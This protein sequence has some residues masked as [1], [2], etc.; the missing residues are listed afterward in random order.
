MRTDKFFKEAELAENTEENVLSA[1]L[2]DTELAVNTEESKLTAF[3][4][5][6]ELKGALKAKEFYELNAAQGNI[7]ELQDTK[8]EEF[9]ELQVILQNEFW[10]LS[11]Q[12]SDNIYAALEKYREKCN[13]ELININHETEATDERYKLIK[14]MYLFFNVQGNS[15]EITNQITN[16]K[17]YLNTHECP[18]NIPYDLIA[19][20]QL[21]V[22]FPKPEKN[23]TEYQ[24]FYKTLQ[25][26]RSNCLLAHR[27]EIEGKHITN[28]F[29]YD[30]HGGN[31]ETMV[32]EISQSFEHF[33]NTRKDILKQPEFNIL[34]EYEFMNLLD[35]VNKDV[36]Q[37]VFDYNEE[38]IPSHVEENQILLLAPTINT[39]K[40][41]HAISVAFYNNL[42]LISDK[43][44]VNP[45]AHLFK[46]QGTADDLKKAKTKIALNLV[47]FPDVEAPKI[48]TELF[49]NKLITALN[50]KKIAYI[51]LQ[52]QYGENC[53]WS[54]SAKSVLLSALFFRMYN[55]V[56]NIDS[57]KALSND[58]HEKKAIDLAGFYSRK[59]RS[60]WSHYDQQH[61]LESYIEH[62]PE[63]SSTLLAYIMLKNP[64]NKE[65]SHIIN[66][67]KLVNELGIVKAID[68]ADQL[69]IKLLKN[70]LGEDS[71]NSISKS[72]PVL[73]KE[74]STKLRDLCIFTRKNNTERVFLL[75]DFENTEENLTNTLEQLTKELI[76]SEIS[77]RKHPVM[78]FDQSTDK[79]ILNEKNQ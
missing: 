77:S 71:Y 50:M 32:A 49:T 47:K 18:E 38:L 43:A 10:A 34:G 37:C 39:E 17:K 70:E 78:F 14:M 36:S 58:E 64:Q 59:I 57:L 45:G 72:F 54:S 73:L 22:K 60:L 66:E 33:L 29:E 68:M 24:K 27:S 52:T 25:T 44:G 63:L 7:E 6:A 40:G 62:C 74:I 55:A 30:L 69:V 35:E 4:L 79:D 65:Y 15:E 23:E 11:E 21:F 28:N 19:K 13:Q 48:T 26:I 20:S 2:L 46:L 61:A 51:P 56:Q 31:T 16:F 75:L 9:R 5:D 42:C 76:N 8:L 3:L 53:S 1:F 67:R 12:V 41:Y